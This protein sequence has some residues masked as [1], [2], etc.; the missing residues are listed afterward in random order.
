MSSSESGQ[1]YRLLADGP[2][3]CVCGYCARRV[4][5]WLDHLVFCGRYKTKSQKELEYNRAHRAPRVSKI[6]AR[7]DG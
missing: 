5:Q 1:S 7:V 4:E 6:E 3:A 2:K